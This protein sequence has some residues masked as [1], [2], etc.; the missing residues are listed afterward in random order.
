MRASGHVCIVCGGPIKGLAPG[1][2]RRVDVATNAI[3]TTYA[4]ALCDSNATIYFMTGWIRG[5]TGHAAD[6]SVQRL[7]DHIRTVAELP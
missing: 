7:I 1:R 4:C 5:R 2:Y 6:A 3:D